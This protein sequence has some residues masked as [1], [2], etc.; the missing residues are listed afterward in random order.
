MVLAVVGEFC[1]F[2]RFLEAFLEHAPN[3]CQLATDLP[4]PFN[5]FT[6]NVIG[7]FCGSVGSSLP[8]VLLLKLHR[9]QL[10]THCEGC[11]FT[12]GKCGKD[13]CQVSRIPVV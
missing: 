3:E 2:T 1:H 6:V 12:R 5:V 13:D 8:I 4:D 7:G 9:V 11:H 10:H